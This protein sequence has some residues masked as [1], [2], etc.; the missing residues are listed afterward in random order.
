M[1]LISEGTSVIL[2]MLSRGVAAIGSLLFVFLSSYYGDAQLV[3]AL[4]VFHAITLGVAILSVCGTNTL[5]LRI[6]SSDIDI[7]GDVYR[8]SLKVV[9]L[10]STLLIIFLM[11]FSKS[12]V[13]VISGAS[14]YEYFLF[15]LSAPAVA[16]GLVVS[17]YMKGAGKAAAAVLYESGIMYFLASVFFL[18]NI[19]L[20]VLSAI[21]GLAASFFLASWVVAL[22]GM[23]RTKEALYGRRGGWSFCKVITES[24]HYWLIS[25]TTF[26][27]ANAVIIIAGYTMTIEDVGIVRVVERLGALIG[28]SLIAVNAVFGRHF[29]SLFALGKYKELKRKYLSSVFFGVIFGSPVFLIFVLWPEYTLSIFGDD[30]SSYG[31]E[32][33]IFCFGALINVMT[34]SVILLLSLSGDQRFVSLVCFINAIFGVLMFWYMSRHGVFYAILVMTTILVSANLIMFSR[35]ILKFRTI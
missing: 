15:L 10:A 31:K 11:L 18:V 35:M 26:L 29:S 6:R 33:R 3:G 24:R 2:A 21:A 23:F 30:F 1:R 12:V 5:V 22:F 9:I 27:Q 14:S 17:G 13:D 34:G 7:G 20:E 25:L 8:S 16:I 4:A 19:Y 32:L 28:F